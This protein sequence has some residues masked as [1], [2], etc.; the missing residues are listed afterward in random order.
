M[1]TSAVYDFLAERNCYPCS[2]HERTLFPPALLSFPRKRE[3]TATGTST[4]H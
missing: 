2:N 1:I 3:S 4:R